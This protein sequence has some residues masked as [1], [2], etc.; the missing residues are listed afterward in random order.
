[1]KPLVSI[2]I[3]AFNVE[4]WIGATLSSALG[5]TWRPIEVIVVDDGSRDGTAAAALAFED[6]GVRVIR[7]PH[8]GA[9]A[10]RNQ[11]FRASRGEYIQ[12]LDADDLLAPDKIER[13][14]AV[15]LAQ[16][17]ARTL[18]SSA[19]GRFFYRTSRAR[20]RPTALWADLSPAEC[21][22][23]KMEQNVFMQTGAW[24]MPRA[25]AE[26]AGQ[27]NTRLLTDDDGEYFA[28][29][30]AQS[31]NVLFVPE[32]R[33]Y[34][35]TRSPASSLSYAGRSGAR[36]ESQLTAMELQI[37]HLRAMDDSP[38]ARAACVTYLQDALS[39]FHARRPDLEAR[40]IA[41][42]SALGGRLEPPRLAWKYRWLEPFVGRRAAWH[43]QIVLP[44][45]RWG[46]VR[47]WDRIGAAL[48]APRRTRVEAAPRSA[49]V[50]R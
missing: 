43:A 3:P 5:Q 9:A 21:M 26:A 38:R 6:R 46:L 47:G 36:L 12:Y 40:A 27:W 13:Q 23:R 33:M 30:L 1:M 4:R 45:M 32:A 35:R 19:W 10:A 39:L 16:G 41:Q 11:A 49:C 15:A 50:D 20:F 37:A 42:A 22:L 18:L 8:G 48:E 25:L 17:G 44:R 31:R 24:L 2:L 34:Y 29:V 28:R 7:Q 14:L